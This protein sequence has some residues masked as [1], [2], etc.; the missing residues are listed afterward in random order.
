ALPHG[1][2]PVALAQFVWLFAQIERLPDRRIQNHFP[3]LRR[4]AIHAGVL[5]AFIEAAVSLVDNLE[6]GLAAVDRLLGNRRRQRQSGDS[7]IL[8]AWARKAQRVVVRSE[9]A[10][11]EVLLILTMALPLRSQ[12]IRRNAIPRAGFFGDDRADTGEV[13]RRIGVMS[14][15]G[16]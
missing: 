15:D 14:G 4:E 3:G 12:H 5:G 8:L 11:A 6:E 16:V 1:I 10:C 7:K 9:K 2:A 13:H